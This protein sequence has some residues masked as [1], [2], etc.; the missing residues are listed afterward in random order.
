MKLV[1]TGRSG[2]RVVDAALV[3]IGSGDEQ[4]AA[5][6]SIDVGINGAGSWSVTHVATGFRIASGGSAASALEAARIK[7]ES[8]TPQQ[9]A[10][11]FAHAEEIRTA[12]QRKV[13][14]EVLQ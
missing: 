7:W 13:L 3:D 6:R 11:A 5:H 10:M 12:R 8:T 4:F 1:V 14:G 9:H 2:D